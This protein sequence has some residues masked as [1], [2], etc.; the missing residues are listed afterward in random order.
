MDYK[1]KK[2]KTLKKERTK[3]TKKQVYIKKMETSV[4]MK[5]ILHLTL[6]HTFVH[7]ATARQ[8]AGCL[9]ILRPAHSTTIDLQLASSIYSTRKE[10]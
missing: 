4:K 9:R 5:D 8:E 1:T 2:N 3:E 7:G 10:R 6:Q